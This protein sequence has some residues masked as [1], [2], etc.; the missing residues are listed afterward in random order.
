MKVKKISISVGRTVNLGNFN[1]IR[2][3]LSIEAD[4][5]S[6]EYERSI[7]GLHEVAEYNLEKIINKR[8]NKIKASGKE[9]GLTDE[10][11]FISE[12]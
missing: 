3:E 10:E 9:R 12:L 8:I 2:T 4:V 1:S 11:E 5:D 6:E 7:E